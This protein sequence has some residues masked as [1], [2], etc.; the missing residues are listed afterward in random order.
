MLS[1]Q[2]VVEYS[3]GDHLML[4]LSAANLAWCLSQLGADNMA[5]AQGGLDGSLCGSGSTC[6]AAMQEG[7][8]YIGIDNDQK[9][10]EIAKARL[11]Y[12]TARNR[13]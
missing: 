10:I 3:R 6:I 1:E 11:A 4:P 13:G 8:A 5:P 7:F 9:S 2:E 12:W